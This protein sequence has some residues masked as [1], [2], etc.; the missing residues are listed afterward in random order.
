MVLIL[1][2]QRTYLAEK[3][4]YWTE[5]VLS[6]DGVSLLRMIRSEELIAHV[7]T[8]RPDAQHLVPLPGTVR[9]PTRQIQAV[10]DCAW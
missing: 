1:T 3:M 10:I 9:I 2:D 6:V 8:Q 5:E 7:A 4:R